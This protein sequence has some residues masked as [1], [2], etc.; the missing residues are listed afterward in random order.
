MTGEPIPMKGVPQAPFACA[1]VAE[2]SQPSSTPTASTAA[3]WA[4][5]FGNLIIG[6]GVLLPAGLLNVLMADFSLT[7]SQAGRLMLVGGI[8]VGIGAPVFA[9][10]TSRIERRFL[11][12]ASLLL[13]AAGHLASAL[14]P[15][16]DLQLIIRAV[17]VVGAAIFTPQAASTV[18]LLVP[19]EKRAAAIA[20]IFIGWSAASVA[21]IPLGTLL[22]DILGWRWVYALMG[23]LALISA[24][25]VWLTL[26]PGLYVTPLSAAA[27][28]SA[29]SSPLLWLVFLVTLCSMSGQFTLFGYIAPILKQ[30]FG[31]NAQA[32]SVMF[33]VVGLSGVFGNTLASRVVGRL[34]VDR[35]IAVGLLSLCVGFFGVALSWGN[36]TAAM[37]AAI[38]WGLGSFSSNSLQQSRLVALAPP[39]A[40]AT[41]A[42]NTSVVYLGQSMGS[43]TGGKLVDSGH[44]TSAPYVALGFMAA[45]LALSVMATRLT[46]RQASAS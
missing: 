18:G 10:L 27:W 30:G 41:V 4:F 1:K 11:L 37:V 2:M 23:G 36:L 5:L 19:T 22:A 3:L 45:A 28:K 16:F 46:R 33:A 44:M 43:W 20:F 26:R 7:A 17:T 31:A 21:G 15:S 13:Y 25:A 8:V 39:L 34:G 38:F 12:T 40:A 6:T 24:L 9:A 14:A 32:I 35:V 42:L 29:L